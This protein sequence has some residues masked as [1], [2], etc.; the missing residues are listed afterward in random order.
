M[1]PNH[2]KRKLAATLVYSTL[3]IA[4]GSLLVYVG[5]ISGQEF[6]SL[7][8]AAGAVVAVYLGANVASGA[9]GGKK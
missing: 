6:V 5:K 9:F 3:V 4:I 7:L 1:L 8:N 2:G